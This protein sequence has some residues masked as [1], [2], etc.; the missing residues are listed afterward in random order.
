[1]DKTTELIAK[2]ENTAATYA[3][4]LEGA[5]SDSL[6]K[7]PDEKN[8]A[9]V[10]IICHIRDVEESYMNSF[11]T[12]L[13]VEDFKFQA[14]Y[15]DRWAEERQYL[16]NDTFR[17]L[18]AFRARRKETVEFL[19]AS[20]PEQWER[21]GIHPRHGRRTIAELVKGLADHD[22]NHLDQLKRAL[23]GQA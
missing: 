16:R 23:A 21:A 1:M 22:S 11:K 6:T 12:I 19:K 7:R 18:S 10:E 13:E 3:S 9:P 15:A 2:L 20:K 4:T 8:W 14:G 5:S 17:A